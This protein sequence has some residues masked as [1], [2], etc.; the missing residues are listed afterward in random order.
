MRVRTSMNVFWCS[1][2]LFGCPMLVNADYANSTISA[3]K[4]ISDDFRIFQETGK[5]IRRRDGRNLISFNTKNDNIEVKHIEIYTNR[6]SIPKFT[7][8]ETFQWGF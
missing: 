1:V 7:R 8:K 6:P 5:P 2:L 4:S 3:V